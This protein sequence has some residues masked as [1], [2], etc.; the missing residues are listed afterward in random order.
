MASFSLLPLEYSCMIQRLYKMY[1]CIKSIEYTSRVK[2][3]R[4]FAS[5]K[6]KAEAENQHAKI[7]TGEKNGP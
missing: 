5:I 2:K 7:S 6:S 1:R 4:H 3:G